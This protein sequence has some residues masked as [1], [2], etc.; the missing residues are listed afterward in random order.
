VL[1][2]VRLIQAALAIWG[3]IPADMG[4]DGLFCDETKKGLFAWRRAMGMEHEDS[5]RLEVG[6]IAM[7]C[8]NC[9][10]MNRKKRVEGVLTQKLWRYC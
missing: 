3:M 10:L 9:I 1:E 4:I 7:G 5:M 6:G 2:L 8:K